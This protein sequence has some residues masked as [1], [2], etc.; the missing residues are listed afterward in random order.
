MYD[1]NDFSSLRAM[2]GDE[3]EVLYGTLLKRVLWF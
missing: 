2:L 1:E 3:N